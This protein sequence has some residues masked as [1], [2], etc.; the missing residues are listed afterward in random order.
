MFIDPTVDMGIAI[1]ATILL[2]V[3]GI[4]AGLFPARKAANVRPIEALNAR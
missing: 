1:G 2:I 4:L 3:A